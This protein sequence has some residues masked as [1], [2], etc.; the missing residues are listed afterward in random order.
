MHKFAIS[1]AA[2]K[3]ELTLSMGENTFALQLLKGDWVPAAEDLERMQRCLA[4]AFPEKNVFVI[5]ASAS[6]QPLPEE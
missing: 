4:F 1:D 5:G 6:V 3:T 2:T